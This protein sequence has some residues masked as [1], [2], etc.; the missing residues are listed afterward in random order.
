MAWKKSRAEKS[1]IMI[2]GKERKVLAQPIQVI[3]KGLEIVDSFKYLGSKVRTDGKCSE[4]VR[5]RLAMATS[6][7]MNLSS[8]LQN[9][10]F[11][12][13]TKYRLLT[14]IARAIALHGCET[15]TTDAA[16]QKRINAFE[17]KCYRKLLRI[18]YT[19]HG[20]NDSVKRNSHKRLERQ[21]C[22][23]Q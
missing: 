15:W 12:I 11:S 10:S 14:T 23:Y 1:K 4:E 7:L 16:L 8:I 13:K 17:M 6:S 5:S 21:K 2:V 19:A 18:P 22:W 9:S 20:T 3:G